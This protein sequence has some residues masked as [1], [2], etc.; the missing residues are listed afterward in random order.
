MQS[1][2]TRMRHTEIRVAIANVL[3][4]LVGSLPP[5]ALQSVAALRTMVLDHISSSH[6][7]LKSVAAGAQMYQCMLQMSMQ[8]WVRH[9]NSVVAGS[10]RQIAVRE[11]WH[12]WTM[13][14]LSSDVQH[15][16]A[17]PAEV[18]SDLQQ[19][20]LCLATV[21]RSTAVELAEAMPTTCPASIR[22]QLF[23]LFS[24]WSMDASPGMNSG[25]DMSAMPG[26][27]RG[28]SRGRKGVLGDIAWGASEH[29]A[30]RTC[31]K[32]AVPM[33]DGCVLPGG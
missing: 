27:T 11:F 29:P 6:R 20:R 24:E 18:S 14:T 26:P 8:G 10:R 28:I 9:G 23:S 33:A 16:N 31:R 5:G 15:A 7:H 30:R 32:L 1:K 2:Q 13:L 21:A 12:L 4:L 17:M 22:S 25:E 3:R 19:Q